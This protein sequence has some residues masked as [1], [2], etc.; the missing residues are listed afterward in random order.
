MMLQLYG[1]IYCMVLEL[2]K[3]TYMSPPILTNPLYYDDQYSPLSWAFAP[4]TACPIL[5]PGY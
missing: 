2:I 1:A 5:I 4:L 3:C